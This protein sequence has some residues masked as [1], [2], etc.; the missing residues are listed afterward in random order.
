MTWAGVGLAAAGTLA[1]LV[2]RQTA[3]ERVNFAFVAGQVEHGRAALVAALLVGVVV[4][5]LL[6]GLVRRKAR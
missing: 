1:V 5:L 2:R 3:V 4:G 6:P